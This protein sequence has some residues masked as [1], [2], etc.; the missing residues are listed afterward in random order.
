MGILSFG[1]EGRTMPK[2]NTSNWQDRTSERSASNILQYIKSSGY[3]TNL[4]IEKQ[5]TRLLANIEKNT[6]REK[7]A[8]K[9]H[10]EAKAL[11]CKLIINKN[12]QLLLVL[13]EFAK[14]SFHRKKDYREVLQVQETGEAVRLTGGAL[15]PSKQGKIS[16]I[17]YPARD[18]KI[19][20]EEK[21]RKALV[22]QRNS[23]REIEVKQRKLQM[24]FKELLDE[25][26]KGKIYPAE[27]QDELTKV[28]GDEK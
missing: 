25:S 22:I 21:R 11:K 3:Q 12:I 10:D 5:K 18:A 2:Q 15:V 7:K 23:E 28:F 20:K 16:A 24:S 19:E 14:T 8:L 26:E 4:D 9:E 17:S 13:N 1:N 27:I 6:R